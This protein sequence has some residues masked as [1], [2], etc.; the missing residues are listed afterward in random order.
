MYA[1]TSVSIT[2]RKH[3]DRY[4]DEYNKIYII[5]L[6]SISYYYYAVF[7]KLANQNFY[8]KI[9]HLSYIF[10]LISKFDINT[11]SNI[12]RNFYE[13]NLKSLICKVTVFVVYEMY[14]KSNMP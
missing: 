4:L 9:S 10:E 7:K 1:H 5:Y 13:K 11:A 6:D 14:K 8:T 12:R 2:T 3:S